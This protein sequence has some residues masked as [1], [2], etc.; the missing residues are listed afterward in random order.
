MIE[1]LP[2]AHAGGGFEPIDPDTVRL[3]WGPL[4]CGSSR[5]RWSV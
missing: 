2:R 5:V 1:G 3:A 4:R